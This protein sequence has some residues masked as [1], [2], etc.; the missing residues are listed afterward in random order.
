MTEGSQLIRGLEGVVAAET[1][2]CDLD[3]RNGR[4]AYAGYDIDELARQATFEEVAYLLWHD[5]LPT[6][7]ELDR[8][9]TELVAA[10]PIPGDLVRAFALMPRETD[11][12]RVLQAAVA[13]LGMHDPDTT[14]NS[15]PANLRKAARLASQFATAICA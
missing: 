3:G 5:A 13:V 2:L 1:R 6:R 14:D 9:R 12:M 8:F 4:L 15:R 11:P 7:A 10:R